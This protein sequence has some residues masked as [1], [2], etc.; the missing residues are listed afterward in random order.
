VAALE[1]R[2]EPDRLESVALKP[3][4]SDVRV[5]VCALAWT[6]YWRD[7]AGALTPAWT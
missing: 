7:Q 6:P 5:R 1:A 3:K 4:K 2:A